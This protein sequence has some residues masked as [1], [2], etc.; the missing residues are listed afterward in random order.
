VTTL[1]GPLVGLDLTT[2]ALIGGTAMVGDLFSS[3][4]KRRLH[5]A[6]SSRAAGLDQI[7]ESLFPLVACRCVLSLTAVDILIGSAAFSVGAIFLSPLFR[8]VGIRDQP[9]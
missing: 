7:P 3:F 8:R 5:F 9:F 2:G 6:T 4:V 1:A